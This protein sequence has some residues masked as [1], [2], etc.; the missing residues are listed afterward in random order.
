VRQAFVYTPPGYD[1]NPSARYP[2][3]YLVQGMG[4]DQRAWVEQGRLAEIL[5]NL[6]ARG[7]AQEMIVVVEDAGT[8]AGYAPRGGSGRGATGRGRG[9]AGAAFPQIFISETVPM[10]DA[11]YR[12]IADREHRA[13]AG[14]SLGAA[15]MFQI[16]QDHVDLFSHVGSFSAPFGY[17]AVPSG[18]DGLLGD[19]DEFTKRIKTLY[20]SAGSTEANAGARMFQEQLEAAGIAHTYYE[21]PGN[22]HGWHTW[23]KSLH[24]FVQLLFKD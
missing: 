9:N 15:Q 16:T 12:T 18:Y 6:I 2:V 21:A 19:P 1:A 13:M 4:E 8:A 10:I 3:L 22:G 23:R 7:E 5:D 14:A 17:P 24:G 20:V 11:T